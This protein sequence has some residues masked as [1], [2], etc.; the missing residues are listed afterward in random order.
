LLKF[1]KMLNRFTACIVFLLFQTVCIYAQPTIF[2]KTTGHFQLVKF[3]PE[4][5]G[6]EKISNYIIGEIA[7]S[8]PKNIEFTTFSVEFLS[9]IRLKKID[10]TKYSVFGELKEM[11]FSGDLFYRNI[12]IAHLLLP[13]YVDFQVIVRNAN[14]T[15]EIAFEKTLNKVALSD[16]M[17]YFTILQTQFS[18]NNPNINYVASFE[19]LKLL[20]DEPVKERFVKISSLINEYF[21]AD[22]ILENLNSTLQSINISQLE[23]VAFN[24]I[25]L[26]D[27]EK[28]FSKL[29]QFNFPYELNL[30]QTDPIDFIQRMEL[31]EH[32]IEQLRFQINKNLE[33]LDQMY[34]DKGIE[35]MGSEKFDSAGYYFNKAIEYNL[36]FVPAIAEMA[37]LDYRKD[38]L[39]SAASRISF[40]HEYTIVS[41][42]HQT[43]I[44]E[45]TLLI[46]NAIKRKCAEKNFI[47]ELC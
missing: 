29:K 47:T 4:A 45:V 11:K 2:E 33:Q 5:V 27:V 8:I 25:V 21:K 36:V 43:R 44:N 1:L 32:N 20:W 7:R 39:D 24:N 31:L 34:Y 42:E 22:K 12:N 10:S 6:S 13:D 18:D 40:I 23:R 37:Y 17:G 3:V 9:L 35:N 28:E 16:N 19:N 14:N 26:K 41:P 15:S 46:I 30:F 38:H